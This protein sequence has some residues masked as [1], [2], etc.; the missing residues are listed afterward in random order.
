MVENILLGSSLD[1]QEWTGRRGG[2]NDAN[3]N[4][5]DYRGGDD[6]GDDG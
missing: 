4:G 3:D 1:D 2:R 6:D 5:E